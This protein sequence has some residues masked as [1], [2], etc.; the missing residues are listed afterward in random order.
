M[1][2]SKEALN[3]HQTRNFRLCDGFPA[4]ARFALVS[5]EYHREANDDDKRAHS[6]NNKAYALQSMI[7]GFDI[8]RVRPNYP[9]CRELGK[10]I[11]S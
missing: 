1:S 4:Y 3:N 11:N 8:S 6:V 7:N 10:R 2:S 9:K 5:K